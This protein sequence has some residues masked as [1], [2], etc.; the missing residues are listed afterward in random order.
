[1][2]LNADDSLVWPVIAGVGFVC[3]G[4]AGEHD[5]SSKETES[6]QFYHWVNPFSLFLALGR[7]KKTGYS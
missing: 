1:L 3:Y 5:E 4:R 2:I 7:D 6:G